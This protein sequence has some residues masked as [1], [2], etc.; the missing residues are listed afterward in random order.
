MIVLSDVNGN[1]DACAGEVV[2]VYTCGDRLDCDPI[3]LRSVVCESC[4]D[5]CRTARTP[6]PQRN[7][8]A[9]GRVKGDTKVAPAGNAGSSVAKGN[10]SAESAFR[11][12]CYR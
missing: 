6:G 4:D 1:V 9:K 12:Q 3:D 8:A 7:P 11:R 5:N 10:V 2:W